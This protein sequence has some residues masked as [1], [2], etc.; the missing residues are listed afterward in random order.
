MSSRWKWFKDHEID[1]LTDDMMFR[2]D[3]ARGIYG[4]PII[5]SDGYRSPERNKELGGT[6]NSLHTKGLAVDIKAPVDPAMREKLCWALGRAGFR[7]VGRYDRHYHMEIDHE[8]PN[9]AWWEGTSK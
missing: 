4:H 7:Q 9:D 2:L 5:I 8:R 1:G 6:P 3:R